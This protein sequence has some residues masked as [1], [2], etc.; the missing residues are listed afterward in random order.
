MKYNYCGSSGLLLP[1]ISLGLWHNFGD[2]DNFDV[3]KTIIFHAFG[4]GI[5][6]FDL[7]NNYGPPPGSAESTF[8]KVLAKELKHHRDELIIT[9]KAGHLMWDG[10][11]GDGSSRKYI[12]SS[13][14]QSLHRTGLE[15]FDIFYS[16]RYNAETPLEE[17]AQALID[18]VKQ[19]KAL[20]IG[21]SK[22]PADKAEIMYNLMQ[23]Q[24]VK[25][26]VYQDK[27]NLLVRHIE[28]KHIELN[29]KHGVGFVSFSPLAQG[30]LTDKYLKGIPDN[31]RAA[32]SHGF[33]QKEEID[34]KL[35]EKISKLNKIALDR[36]QSLAQMALA[37][38]LSKQYVTSVIVGASSVEQLQD[39]IEATNNTSFTNEEL[40]QIEQI[41]SQ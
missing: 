3:A 15:Y 32:K 19:G 21:L 38:Q 2:V 23:K 28:E 26:L 40:A 35:V 6:H 30:L 39:N 10:P 34:Q 5:T 1:Q 36:E 9:S 4:S 14:N 20:Y 17:T 24:H 8:G 7:A 31:S 33:L 37:W 22:Y 13:I 27:Y 16:H 18:I 25:C 41:I 29:K 12:M 11:Y